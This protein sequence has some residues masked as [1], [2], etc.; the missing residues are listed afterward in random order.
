MRRPPL[1]HSRC[2]GTKGAG[3]RSWWGGPGW[4]KQGRAQVQGHQAC[5][6][7]G[8]TDGCKRHPRAWGAA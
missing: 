4:R 8:P 1:G 5:V 7:E 6:W 2:P 3:D